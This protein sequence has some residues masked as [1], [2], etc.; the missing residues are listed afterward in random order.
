[1][2]DHEWIENHVVEK[3]PGTMWGGGCPIYYRVCELCDQMQEQTHHDLENEEDFT[4]IVTKGLS[5]LDAFI[6]FEECEGSPS[7]AIYGWVKV[8]NERRNKLINIKAQAEASYKAA[9][10]LTEKNRI[11]GA[12][13]L[14]KQKGILDED[15]NYEYEMP[16]VV[17]EVEIQ[18]YG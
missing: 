15:F 16:Q 1:M 8:D 6:S 14:L 11:F 17:E 2:C 12:I 13:Q 18:V 7:G 10:A 9:K 5:L 3:P 4:S